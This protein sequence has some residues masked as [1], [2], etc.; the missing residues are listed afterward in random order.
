M[1]SIRKIPEAVRLAASQ[2]L[3]GMLEADDGTSVD[4]VI[5][6]AFSDASVARDH[7]TIAANAWGLENFLKNPVFLWAHDA[8]EPPIGRV[9]NLGTEN[10]IL[11]GEVEYAD[12]DTYPFAD[13]VYR[14]VK[15]G[16]INATSTSWIPLDWTIARDKSRPGGVDFTKVELLEISQVPVP[17]LPTALVE[18]R[19][20]GIDTKPVFDW[21]ERMLDSGGYTILPRAQL[22]ALRVEAKMP[23]TRKVTSEVTPEITPEVTA[24]SV[25][26]I[27]R[28][29]SRNARQR[30]VDVHATMRSAHITM[31]S[32]YSDLTG[33]LEDQSLFD[34]EAD[35][36]ASE[37]DDDGDE[38]EMTA[39]RLRKARAKARQIKL[40]PAAAT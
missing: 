1:T 37:P 26:T 40:T 25:P 17:A 35:E 23:A 39:R 24:D 31:S 11:R 21:A 6:Y 27:E 10:G 32:A 22:E 36:D 38:D 9:V 28:A 30:L 18:A 16:F 19:H 14:L 8:G 2:P 15:G 34:N 20:Q 5:R 33:M 7:H 29:L 13:T 4:R 12:R 3:F